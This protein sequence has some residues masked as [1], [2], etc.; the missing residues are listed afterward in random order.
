MRSELL[1]EL[2]FPRKREPRKLTGQ[3][4]LD[5][6]NWIPACAGMTL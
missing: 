3:A 2:S 5:L 6:Q 1:K 4:H